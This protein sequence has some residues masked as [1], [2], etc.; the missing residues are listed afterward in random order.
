MAWKALCPDSSEKKS[1]GKSN[2]AGDKIDMFKAE[3]MN[4]CIKEVKQV[5]DEAKAKG[6]KPK[7]HL[8]IKTQWFTKVND[9][10][11]DRLQ[12]KPE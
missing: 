1:S 10:H 3:V 2:H 9:C 12:A 11:C 7:M 5:E 6:M 4:A 8:R